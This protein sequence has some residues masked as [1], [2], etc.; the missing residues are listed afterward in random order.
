M[1]GFSKNS[2]TANQL[3]NDCF[4]LSFGKHLMQN[5]ALAEVFARTPNEKIFLETDS[6]AYNLEEIYI[7]AAKCKQI[8]TEEMKT[9]VFNNFKSV[10]KQ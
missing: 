6:S 8:S 4:Y 2:Q 7:F 3:L 9:I 5:P 10:F 1:H